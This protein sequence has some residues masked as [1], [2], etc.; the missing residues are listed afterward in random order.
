MAWQSVWRIGLLGLFLAVTSAA[1]ARDLDDVRQAGVLRHL[2]I[3]YANFVT[4][5]GDG[6]DV[7][8]MQG[9]ARHLGVR[10][11]FIKTDWNRAFGDLAGRQVRRTDSGIQWLGN[12]PVRGDVLAS[13]ITTLAWRGEVVDFSNPTFPSG[14]WLVAR[15]QSSLRPITPTGSLEADIRKLKQL[16]RGRSVLALENTCLDPG[17]YDIAKTGARVKL[18]NSTLQLNEMAPAVLNGDAET[19]LLDVPDALIALDKWPGELKVI[20]PVS[21]NQ[22]MSVAFR[23]SSPKLRAAFNQ[24]LEKVW[25]DGSYIKLV[26]RYYPGVFDYY[27]DFF[28]TR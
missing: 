16:M 25:R 9:F 10:Y 27:R 19:T 12:V 8:L 26:Q 2:G 5:S 7:E 21:G 15:A 28:E 20:G 13:G 17:L 11:E 18:A 6:L 22:E 24:Y 23:K 14:V 4:G 3:P 1:C